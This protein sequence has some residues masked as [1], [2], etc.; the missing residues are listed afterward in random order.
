MKTKFEGMTL[1]YEDKVQTVGRKRDAMIPT[2]MRVVKLIALD[3]EPVL[4]A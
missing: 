3:I 4:I 2:R 1:Y